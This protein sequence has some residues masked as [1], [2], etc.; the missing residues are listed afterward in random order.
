MKM[1]QL[2]HVGVFSALKV[3]AVL[4]AVLGLIA[5]A[6]FSLFSMV[7]GALGGERSGMMGM[8]FGVGAIIIFPILYGI[9]GAIAGA[10]GALI[11]NLVARFTG[12][13]ELD[14]S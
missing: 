3:F 8:L 5:G 12:G 7:G 1:A 2:K 9:I 14:L 10:I 4:H 11:Y 13:L 6:M